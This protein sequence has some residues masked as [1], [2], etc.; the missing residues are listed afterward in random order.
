LY[1]LDIIIAHIVIV[2]PSIFLLI[3]FGRAIF[4][5]TLKTARIESNWVKYEAC[6]VT[7]E[8]RVSQSLYVYGN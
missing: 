4:R 8:R 2:A 7:F 3:L 1:T 6:H 5:R